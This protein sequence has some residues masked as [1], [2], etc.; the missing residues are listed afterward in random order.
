MLGKRL[1]ERKGYPYV[2]YAIC[3]LMIFCGLG[4]LS[5]SRGIYLAPITDALNISR[6]SYSIGDSFRYVTST[7]INI[8]FGLL[9]GR[10]GTKKLMCAGLAS[11]TIA[12]ILNATARNVIGFYIAGIFIGIGYSWT[13][14]SM[15]ACVV[16]KWC[17]NNVG[18]IMGIILRC[19]EMVQK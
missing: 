5:S 9:V 8:F 14:T 2:V 4:F 13:T 17:K 6:A 1:S 11:L 18:T 3:F 10:F 19:I 7:V 12:V 15:V 16:S